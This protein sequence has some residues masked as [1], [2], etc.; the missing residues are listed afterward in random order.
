MSKSK[1][2]QSQSPIKAPLPPAATLTSTVSTNAPALPHWYA[3]TSPLSAHCSIST[4]GSPA[5]S[6]FSAT[7]MQTSQDFQSSTAIAL[8]LSS[9]FDTAVNA[10]KQMTHYQHI[11]DRRTDFV[12]HLDLVHFT[13]LCLRLATKAVLLAQQWISSAR[14][15]VCTD[16]CLKRMNDLQAVLETVNIPTKGDF[17]V[18][19]LL[20][21]LREAL[22]TAT[23]V[24]SDTE[25]AQTAVVGSKRTLPLG[26][27]SI[28]EENVAKMNRAEKEIEQRDDD[29]ASSVGTLVDEEDV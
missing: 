28:S 22:P 25:K 23:S 4:T 7:S 1:A 16:E 10:L 20:A 27:A 24:S 5:P 9:V 3:A 19:A 8:V 6:L 26:E 12:K 14:G 17:D 11:A 15:R 18:L 21:E 2:V 13:K 29:D